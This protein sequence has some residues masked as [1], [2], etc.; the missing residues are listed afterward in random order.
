MSWD[1]NLT[2]RFFPPPFFSF[3]FQSRY[4]WAAGTGCWQ[5]AGRVLGQA[6]PHSEFTLLAVK[7][8]NV[9]RAPAPL[10]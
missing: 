10:R 5:G 9:M 3:F 1:Q 7:G 6:S 4:V 2:Q 8:L